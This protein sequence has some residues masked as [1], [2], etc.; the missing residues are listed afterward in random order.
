M[1]IAALPCL[2]F[3]AAAV[4][5]F[6]FGAVWYMTLAKPW[7][8]YSRMTEEKVAEGGGGL[9]YVI[10]ASSSLIAAVATALVLQAAGITSI[11]PAITWG[12]LLGLG[13]AGSA[14][15]KHY[16]FQGH[17]TG[18]FLIDAG[19]DTLGFALMAVV[20]VALS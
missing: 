16:A 5:Y 11:G 9:T 20:L 13:V 19:Y 4:A 18:L 17:P 7:M 15:A 6:I 1:N 3:V 10:A 2:A 8:R 12:L 14:I